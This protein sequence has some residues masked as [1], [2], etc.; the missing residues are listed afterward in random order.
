MLRCC[1]S[2]RVSKNA[3]FGETRQYAATRS[4][5]KQLSRRQRKWKCLGS[6][7]SA[8]E[9]QLAAPGGCWPRPRT[10]QYLHLHPLRYCQD[11]DTQGPAR[12]AP[13]PGSTGGNRYDRA[14][15]GGRVVAPLRVV[16][17]ALVLATLPQP[18]HPSS[19]PIS[20]CAGVRMAC[21][22]SDLITLLRRQKADQ[23]I[24]CAIAGLAS[25]R[26]RSEHAPSLRQRRPGKLESLGVGRVLWGFPAVVKV[27]PSRI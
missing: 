22:G 12:W 20:G 9:A 10:T 15:W 19:G 21:Q 24:F 16:L 8:N 27:L 14:F 26:S 11:G 4:C 5:R 1:A 25:T 13:G 18:W 3:V 7:S 2:R 17:P 6:Q 23:I